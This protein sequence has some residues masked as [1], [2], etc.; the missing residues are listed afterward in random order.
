MRYYVSCT[1]FTCLVEIENDGTIVYAAPILNRF[2]GQSFTN[3][4]NWIKNWQ[5][6][7]KELS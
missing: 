6:I 7:I 2:I 4:K 5:P 3:L 1:K